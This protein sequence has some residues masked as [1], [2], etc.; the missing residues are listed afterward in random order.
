LRLQYLEAQTK[1]LIMAAPYNSEVKFEGELPAIGAVVL[2]LF[3][4]TG[5]MF[6]CKLV[7]DEGGCWNLISRFPSMEI[8]LMQYSNSYVI[9]SY[10]LDVS[11]WKRNS[12]PTLN[13]Y[14]HESASFALKE[15]G[16]QPNEALETWAGESWDMAKWR[17]NPKHIDGR[18][19]N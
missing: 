8:S 18:G 10:P 19:R 15:L 5:L 7:G 13:T 11:V 14:L 6:D 4:V 16:G 9:F 12:R 3:E 17:W 1:L 2:K